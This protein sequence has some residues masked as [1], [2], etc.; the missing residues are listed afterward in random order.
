MLCTHRVVFLKC[1]VVCVFRVLVRLDGNVLWSRGT[2]VVVAQTSRYFSN[3]VHCVLFWSQKRYRLS[4]KIWWMSVYCELT[5]NSYW[6][7]HHWRQ[8]WGWGMDWTL[9]IS[10]WACDVVVAQRLGCQTFDQVVAGSIPG[11]GVVK[12][13]RSTQP[14]IP[15]G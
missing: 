10:T 7:G 15:P 4:S 3:G 5:I 6:A 14:S 13:P 2:S 8:D 1:T 9:Y 11:E 12:S